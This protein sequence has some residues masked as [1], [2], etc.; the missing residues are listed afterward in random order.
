MEK[1]ALIREMGNCG[2]LEKL[3]RIVEAIKTAMA[4]KTKIV[5]GLD[6][7]VYGNS[8]ITIDQIDSYNFNKTDIIING[9]SYPWWDVTKLNLIF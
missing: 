3:T 7:L 5:L 1:R 8:S 2:S 4:H 6:P 9:N